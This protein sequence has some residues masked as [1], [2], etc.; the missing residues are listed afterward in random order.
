MVEYGDYQCPFCKRFHTQTEPLLVEYYIRAGKV[1][2]TYR[3]AG[4]WVSQNIGGGNTESQDAALAAYCAADQDHFWDMYDAL[5]ANNL[6]VENGG[7][8]TSARLSTIAKSIG[9]DMVAFQDCYDSGK[10]ADQV[11][12]D[13]SDAYSAGIQ[14]TPFFVLTYTVNGEAQAEYISGA[15]PISEFQRVIEA[16][17]QVAD[18]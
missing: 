2:F 7:A 6:D 14:G 1:L 11:Q 15:Q 9:L 17:L 18:Q 4:N 3:S 8:F 10:Y 12:Q 16:I 13:L 5:Y